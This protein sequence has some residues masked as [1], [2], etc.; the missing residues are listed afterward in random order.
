MGRTQ[1]EAIMSEIQRGKGR[2]RVASRV[3]GKDEGK[4]YTTKKTV[5]V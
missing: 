5:T 3:T 1:L 4:I 2:K